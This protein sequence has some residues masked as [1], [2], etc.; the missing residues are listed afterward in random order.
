MRRRDQKL[1]FWSG[2]VAAVTLTAAAWTFL[3][4]AGGPAGLQPV[5]EDALLSRG[6]DRLRDNPQGYPEYRHQSTGIVMVRLPGGTVPIGVN[7]EYRRQFIEEYGRYQRML[8]ARKQGAVVFPDD[9][10]EL[11]PE[12]RQK[13]EAR[14]ELA[15]G[16]L[17]GHPRHKVTLTSFL[18]AKYEVTQGQWKSAMGSNPSKFKINGAQNPAERVSWHDCRQFCDQVGLA[19]PSEAQWEY[20]CRAGSEETFAG[21]GRIDDMAWYQQNSGERTHPVGQKAP[22]DFGLYDMHGNVAE[23]CADAMDWNFYEK[24]QS[25]GVNPVCPSESGYRV[26]RGGAFADG[27]FHSR[28]SVRAQ[29]DPAGGRSVAGGSIGFRPVLILQEQPGL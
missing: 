27:A 13:R 7:P 6:F 28:A 17:S 12:E 18:I 9:E 25:R 14:R 22:N 1:V 23:W 5:P 10:K 4:E 11:N 29:S 3:R 24:P 16:W 21:T 20:A 2:I 26:F 8:M 15:R 19:L